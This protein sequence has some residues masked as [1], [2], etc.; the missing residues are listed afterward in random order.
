[1]TT[2]FAPDA[3]DTADEDGDGV[4]D[5][6]DVCPGENDLD[7]VDGDSVPDGCDVCLGDDR[8]DS[9][10]DGVPN[11]CDE[12]LSPD[13]TDDDGRAD[14]CDVCPGEDDE[15]DADADGV[16]DAC[17]IC[18][19]G[20]DLVDSDSDGTPNA[21]EAECL[22]TSDAD[23]DGVPDDCDVCLGHDDHLDDDGDGVP[24]GCD[25]CPVDE[26]DDSDGDGVCDTDDVC[27]GGRDDVDTDHDG[28][29]DHCDPCPNDADND[30]DEDGA[31]GDVD[32][33]PGIANGGQEDA[34]VDGM[35]D[36]CDM[37]PQDARD[38][39]DGDGVCGDVD[40]CPDAANDDQDDTDLDGLGDLCD[41]CRADADNDVDGDGVCGD[42]DNCPTT[43]NDGQEDTDLDGLGDICDV[44]A[45]DADDDADGDGV[46]GDVDNCPTV[47]NDGQEDTD[48]DGLGDTCDT[49]PFGAE[50]PA[51]GIIILW[52][53]DMEEVDGYWHPVIEGTPDT[54]WYLCDGSVVD[55][56]TLPDMR[57]RFVMGAEGADTIG[58]TGGSESV[59]L[60]VEMMSRHQHAVDTVSGTAGE[61]AH[62]Y[63]DTNN[64]VWDKYL[65]RT[66]ASA[67]VE[68]ADMAVWRESA[69]AGVHTHQMLE[70]ETQPAGSATP[71]PIMLDPSHMVVSYL[72]FLPADGDAPER[73]S[74]STAF[75][76]PLGGIALWSGDL[77]ERSTGHHPI[78]EG[79]TDDRWVFC[80]GAHDTTDYRGQ[81]VQG[82]SDGETIGALGGSRWVSL[83]P[84]QL[85]AH[86][87]LLPSLQT[88]QNAHAHAYLDQRFGLRITVQP[89]WLW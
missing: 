19:D 9:D 89:H 77:I 74:G 55:D 63:T 3:D 36:A 60:T 11:A 49:F 84:E 41:A 12:C 48:L 70:E 33:C 27:P 29:S 56:T 65:S 21:C 43:A 73:E 79:V 58:A 4:A 45:N 52:T 71:T 31:C 39:V 61:H 44:C 10:D 69:A 85:P 53:G 78:S 6:C 15:L 38:D 87:H 66:Y 64:E 47:A 67:I 23:A 24:N 2:T 88:E 20:D 1:M 17:D 68:A 46:C 5:G 40:N 57:D 51:S 82:A 32:N 50:A 25:P 54:E 72:M 83:S 62:S 8:L 16:P 13:D 42:V 18:A 81:F 37:C 14:D 86:S 75:S 34:D 35:G 7:D 59:T 76:A 30:A 26:L 80:D 28:T 22:S